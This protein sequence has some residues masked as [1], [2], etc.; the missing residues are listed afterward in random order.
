MKSSVKEKTVSVA[1]VSALLWDLGALAA[2]GCQF[3]LMV[4]RELASVHC[5]SPQSEIQTAA[6]MPMIRHAVHLTLCCRVP[7]STTRIT[8]CEKLCSLCAAQM[9]HICVA[10]V[11]SQIIEERRVKQSKCCEVYDARQTSVRWCVFTV[12]VSQPRVKCSV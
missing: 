1:S 10:E 9:R 6:K 11:L 5:I 3:W 4:K 12:F 2:D 8:I 7:Q